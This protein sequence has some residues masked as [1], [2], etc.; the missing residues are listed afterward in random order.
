MT[1]ETVEP[2]IAII[3]NQ[4]EALFL[5]A[6]FAEAGQ[7]NRLVGDFDGVTSRR[8]EG[9][10]LSEARW[11]LGIHRKAGMTQFVSKIEDLS[12]SPP[13]TIILTG[14][15]V[16]QREQGELERT[17]RALCKILPR[18]ANVTFTG[19][20]PPNFT[21]SFLRETIEKHSGHKVGSDVQ[22]SYLP[23]YWSGETLQK[24]KEKPKLIGGMGTDGPS[25][26]QETFLAVFPAI[27]TSL[28]LGA[29]EAAG[30]FGPVYRDVL[31][32]LEFELADLCEADGVDYTEAL[33]LCR[34]S[35][36]I[37][38][39]IP[40]TFTGRDSVAS[41]I[42]LNTSSKRGSMSVV[43]AARRINETGEQKVLDLVKNSL[44]LCGKRLRHSRI[45]VL[46]FVGLDSPRDSKLNAPQVIQT[47]ERR[48][49]IISVY[50]GRDSR[51][52]DHGILG[53][54]V[55]VE[56]SPLRAASKTSCALIALDSHDYGEIS[57]QM[58]A[59]EMSHPA[60]IC[61]L[62][63]V[64]EASNVERAGLFYT[65]IGRGSTGT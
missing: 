47:L 22:L 2:K 50:P 32:A 54:R 28:K 61:D 38:L 60:V 25:L 52:F 10:G 21:G 36:T 6:L 62:G 48:G 26:A 16:S 13:S 11:L 44:L 14:H 46:G 7:P 57:P 4:A 35:G 9:G 1:N 45:S 42:V 30:L 64:L 40:R 39:N 5:S 27:S 23:L 63:R 8:D 33:E 51:W 58:L 12:E 34:K 31:R 24:F 15:A 19:L 55:R 37:G 17:T 41:N 56:N 3:G 59:S 49:A 53:G 29:I 43:R 20:C 65:S 18:G